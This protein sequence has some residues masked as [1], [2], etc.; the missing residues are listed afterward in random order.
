MR[1]SGPIGARESAR[2]QATHMQASAYAH[3]YRQGY[4]CSTSTSI[5]PR[6]PK[7]TSR[8]HTFLVNP[9]HIHAYEVYFHTLARTY[10]SRQMPK[11]AQHTHESSTD[12]AII[13]RQHS[14]ALHT[15]PTSRQPRAHRCDTCLHMTSPRRRQSSP[16]SKSS[17][18][19]C[20][21]PHLYAPGSRQAREDSSEHTYATCLLSSTIWT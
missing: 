13:Y 16:R 20:A 11:E 10:A 8:L 7:V 4:I 3:I 17:R 15:C 2:M 5:C 9:Q 21:R 1:S 12:L 19:P 6:P 14:Y 18:I